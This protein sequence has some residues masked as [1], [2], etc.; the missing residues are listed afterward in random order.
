MKI[1]SE[2]PRPGR[3]LH[4]PSSSFDPT[5]SRHFLSRHLAYTFPG[6]LRSDF[7]L[8][9][10]HCLQS[11]FLNIGI[12][13]PVC[14][15][16]GVLPNF[17]ATWHTCVNQKIPAPVST[18]NISGL[19]SSLPSAF[20]DFIR[21]IVV[22]TS[23]TVKTFSSPKSVTSC[24]SKVDA[25]RGFKRSSKYSLPR[26]RILFSSVRML[27]AESLMVITVLM[28]SV[29]TVN[30]KSICNQTEV[31]FTQSQKKSNLITTTYH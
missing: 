12:I 5:I 29:I 31:Y 27:P 6:K 8:Y 25:F 30:W 2:A 7:P 26:E 23:A 16:L 18:F 21:L 13:T 9:F 24:V 3:K 15:S 1:W 28:E 4:W 14:Q 10:I 19:I 22:A 17:H 11:P 20:P